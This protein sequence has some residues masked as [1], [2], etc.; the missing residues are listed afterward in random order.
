MLHISKNKNVLILP[1]RSETRDRS[2]KVFLLE[3]ISFVLWSVIAVEFVA[4]RLPV[5]QI[6][7]SD[8]WN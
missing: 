8:I 1:I 2:K 6:Y 3:T 5:L 4:W 7:W